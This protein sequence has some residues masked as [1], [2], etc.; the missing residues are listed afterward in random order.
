MHEYR[1]KNTFDGNVIIRGHSIR[2]RMWSGVRALHA[3][4]GR[5]A[6]RGGHGADAQHRHQGGKDRGLYPT[7]YYL[8]T[9]IA[10]LIARPTT[11]IIVS[12]MHPTTRSRRLSS[13]NLRK[14][15]TLPCSPLN[16]SSNAYIYH[17]HEE[18]S[19]IGT[20]V[21]RFNTV[22]HSSII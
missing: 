3:E 22:I 1:K 15:I 13:L 9:F 4:P 7:F 20:I 10:V 14:S 12:L 16:L 17:V 19:G 2:L 6:A 8:T 5:R 11:A 21:D 18:L